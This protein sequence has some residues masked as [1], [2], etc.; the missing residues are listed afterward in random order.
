MGNTLRFHVKYLCFCLALMGAFLG[1]SRELTDAEREQ[2]SLELFQELGKELRT[3]LTQA[4]QA[5]GPENAIQVCAKISPQIEEKIS[6]ESGLQLRRIS[7]KNRNPNHAPL[8]WEKE[9]LAQWAKE[10]EKGAVPAVFRQKLN[11]EFRVMK[12]IILDNPTCLKC[13]GEPGK[14]I[15]QATLERIQSEYPNDK[16]KG[17]KLGDLRGAFSA[18]WRI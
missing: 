16:A 3:E 4:V 14:D 11:G 1:C 18:S 15:N 12:P 9:V 5:K 6:K 13:H 10:M 17:Y 7:D 2:K 8:E